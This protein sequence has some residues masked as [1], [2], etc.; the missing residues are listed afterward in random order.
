VQAIRSKQ[1]VLD[2]AEE[3]S[4]QD[5]ENLDFKAD[6]LIILV[7]SSQMATADSSKEL[8][9][10]LAD[11]AVALADSLA[12]R[13]ASSSECLLYIA[14]AY[15]NRADLWIAAGRFAEAR[16]WIEKGLKAIKL[17][18]SQTPFDVNLGRANATLLCLAGDPAGALAI[19]EELLGKDPGS[20]SL[21]ADAMEYRF[22]SGRYRESLEIEPRAL[23]ANR[24]RPGIRM[25]VLSTGV[26]VRALAGDRAGAIEAARKAAEAAEVFKHGGS[27]S[28]WSFSAARVNLEK[29]RHPLAGDVRRLADALDGWT[30]GKTAQDL[31]AALRRFAKA[32]AG[33]R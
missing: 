29:L 10:S 3:R 28:I 1:K 31:A 22:L 26:M 17:A 9:G 21:M 30:R 19:V 33:G 15:M 8:A 14:M 6:N 12:S 18:R 23:E 24:Q 27:V 32:L 7:N 25:V 13:A 5:P 20:A 11:R 16:G 2:L 4:A